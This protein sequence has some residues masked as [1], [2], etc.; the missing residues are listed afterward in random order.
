MSDKPD[1]LAAQAALEQRRAE[2]SGRPASVVPIDTTA[3]LRALGSWDPGKAVLDDE[4]AE[5]LRDEEERARADERLRRWHEKVANCPVPLS[6]TARVALRDRTFE[7][8][9]PLETV[10]GWIRYNEEGDDPQSVL[11]LLGRPGTGK[12]F[13]AAHAYLAQPRWSRPRYAKIR[14]VCQLYRASFGDDA[15]RYRDLLRARLLI[16]DEL[17]TE[18]GNDVEVAQAALHD[19]IDERQGQG[20]T[21]LISNLDKADLLKRY[22]AR[23]IDRLRE[24]AAIREFSGQSMRKGRL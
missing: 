13:A 16:V 20:L 18:R 10:R 2:L 21:L 19:L 3:A 1:V 24:C 9:E 14:H 22:D 11:V 12:T 4:A 7:S 23:T 15:E 17:G 6:T 8:T 5:R